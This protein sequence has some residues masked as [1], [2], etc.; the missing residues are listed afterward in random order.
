MSKKALSQANNPL[1]YELLLVNILLSILKSVD[2]YK[3]WSEITQSDL[4]V[5]N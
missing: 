4:T 5:R 3:P 1:N 2:T